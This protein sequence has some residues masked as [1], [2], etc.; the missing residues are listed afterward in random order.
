MTTQQYIN[1]ARYSFAVSFAIG[2]LIF[3]V[4][5]S[6]PFNISLLRIF[7]LLGLFYIWLAFLYNSVVFLWIC[8]M[9]IIRKND[10]K[11]ILI[12]ASIMLINIP[13]AVIYAVIILSNF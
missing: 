5:Y 10:T 1:L 7:M 2:T 11:S 12:N 3:L 13:I 8:I 4:S 6:Y 9:A